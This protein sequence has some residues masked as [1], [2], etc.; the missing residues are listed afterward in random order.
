M[1]EPAG[2]GWRTLRVAALV[3]LAA[4]LVMLLVAHPF[5]DETYY[6]MWGHHPALSYFDH[7]SLVGWT[8]G[9][10]GAVFG[11]TILGLRLPVLM[12]L[13]GDI[14]LL[15]LLSR[16]RGDDWRGWFWGSVVLSLAIPILFGLTS[17]ALPDHL[18]VF[19]SLAT[20]YAVERWQADIKVRR[21]LYLAGLAIGLATLSKYTGALLGLGLLLYIIVTPRLRPALRSPHPYLAA[22]L[23]IALQVPVVIWNAQHDWASFGFIVGGRHGV[24]SP[25]SFS[26]VSGYLLGAL[27]VLSPFILVPMFR[28][29]LGRNDEHG[30]GRVVFW[31]SSLGFLVAS[32]FANILIHWNIVAYAAVL[33]YLAG[34][35]RSRW[36]A[37]AQIAY[38]TLAIALAAVN[39]TLVPLTALT[40]HADQ[41]SGWSYGWDDIAAAVRE[42]EAS[43]SVGF[44]AATDYALASPL[45]FALAD[46]GVVSL[47]AKRDAYDDWF[48]PAAHQGQT[49]IIVADQWRPLDS[50]LAAQF[51]EVDT[52]KSLD[53][54]RFGKPVDH[55]TIYLARNYAPG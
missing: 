21:W 51:G 11:W 22:L 43:E 18:L 47:S 53:I 46:A 33:P 6:F 42:A 16:R 23:A 27:V 5:M 30:F 54:V 13:I 55:Y 3:L 12:T 34:R 41:T 36:L 45:G 19:F 44:V 49:A 35:L 25:A 17:V 29:A 28:F 1:A 14:F 39:Y 48:D 31:L 32:L 7:P 24:A 10:S 2:F 20:V 8:E 52:V 50:V 37:G 4:K 15:D 40:S 26:G 38:G 9:L